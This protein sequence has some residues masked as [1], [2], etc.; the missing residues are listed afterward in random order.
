MNAKQ[1]HLFLSEKNKQ[2]NT[3]KKT[4]WFAVISQNCVL[5]HKTWYMLKSGGKK[6]GSGELKIW[7]HEHCVSCMF[8]NLNLFGLPIQLVYHHCYIHCVCVCLCFC[9][10]PIFINFYHVT[11]Y[12]WHALHFKPIK[13][14]VYIQRI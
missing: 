6:I 11:W 3:Q 13:K 10:V 4:W 9:C 5:K 14:H 2:T 12:I 7:C 8:I 1:M